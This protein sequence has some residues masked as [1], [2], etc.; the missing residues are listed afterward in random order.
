MTCDADTTLRS[1]PADGGMLRSTNFSLSAL[2]E[3]VNYDANKD[4]STQYSEVEW[5]WYSKQINKITEY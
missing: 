3:L 4:N 5:A 2:E 1:S